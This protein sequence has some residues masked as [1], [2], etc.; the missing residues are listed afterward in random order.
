MWFIFWQLVFGVAAT[1]LGCAEALKVVTLGVAS[2]LALGAD[3]VAALGAA[4]LYC[5]SEWQ[6]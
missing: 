2:V 4:V 5:V 3:V 6:V 1:D